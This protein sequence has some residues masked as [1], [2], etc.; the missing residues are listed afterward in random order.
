RRPRGRRGLKRL[1]GRESGVD[2]VSPPP[3][4]AWIETRQRVPRRPRY[5]RRRPRGRRGL[6]QYEVE[7]F[8][9]SASRRPRGRRGLKRRA[10]TTCAKHLESPPRGRRGLK[11]FLQLPNAQASP[12]PLPRAAWIETRYAKCG[13]ARAPVAA[14]ASGVD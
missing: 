3:R 5:C 14:R 8:P 9:A 1:A 7:N 10:V 4:A 6:K 11:P 12:S 2:S 13:E